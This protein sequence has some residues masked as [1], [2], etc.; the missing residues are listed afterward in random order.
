[1]KGLKIPEY[2]KRFMLRTD[3]S[4][5]GLGAILLQTNDENHW[6]L[7]QW[8]SKKLT[9]TETRYGI[10]EKE[11]LAVYWGIKNLNMN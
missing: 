9:P 10:T 6:V 1:M 11:M 3:A 5:T 8:A 7:I 4:D 2:G